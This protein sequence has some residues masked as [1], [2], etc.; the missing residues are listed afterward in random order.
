M[1]QLRIISLLIC[2]LLLSACEYKELCY[3]HNHYI[4][5]PVVFDWQKSQ[6]ANA[7][8]MTVLFYDMTPTTKG[9]SPRPFE[10]IRYDL[11]GMKG[12]TIRLLPGTYRAIAYNNDTESI[13][14]R[15]TESIATME[16]YTRSS[17]IEEGTKFSRTD[18]SMPRAANTEEEPVILEPDMLW[19][20]SS[21][22]F[23]LH[24]DDEP[25]TIMMPLEPRVYDIV[26]TI[27]NVPN[28][29]YTGQFGGSLTGLAPSVFMESGQQGPGLATEAFDI[30]VIDATTLRMRFRTFGY[31]PFAGSTSQQ[32]KH[33]LTIY[34]ILGDGTK[35]YY[36]EDITNQINDPTQDP[37]DLSVIVELEDLPIPKPMDEESGFHP[38]ID[39][40]QEMNIE[41]KM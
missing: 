20:A 10:P 14:L 35:W 5:V 25:H 29:Q 31:T 11:V 24:I 36:T 30:D 3:D 16:A 2:P 22:T 18:V 37:A 23:T 6:Q 7:K 21:E 1:K 32:S 4:D 33:M 13:L 15:G 17:T 27:S 12:D 38:Q 8:G 34:A 40:W 28:L 9:S 39:D 26:I 19:C 41:V